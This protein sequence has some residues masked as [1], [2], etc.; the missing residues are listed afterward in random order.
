MVNR[1]IRRME[2]IVAATDQPVIV[3]GANLSEAE[4]VLVSWGSS[5]DACREAADRLA[6][7]GR[8]VRVVGIRLLWPFPRQALADALGKK[9]IFVVEAN[10]LAQLARLIR[11]ELPVHDRLASI[12]QYD[13]R[14]MSS[15]PILAA[16]GAKP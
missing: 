13:G 12:L 2:A 14:T 9:P 1:R 16:L 8:H 5:V 3:E 10:A 6:T 7:H 4:A 11:S 15:E